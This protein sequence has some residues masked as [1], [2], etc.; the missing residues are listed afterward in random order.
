M[1]RFI[2]YKQLFSILTVYLST[3]FLLTRATH[4]QSHLRAHI[5]THKHKHIANACLSHYKIEL[6]INIL[7]LQKI[8]V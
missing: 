4:L 8:D 7:T 6:I 3:F 5:Q 1:Q 2:I